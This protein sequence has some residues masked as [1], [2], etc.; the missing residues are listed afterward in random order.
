MTN[1]LALNGMKKVKDETTVQLTD[2]HILCLTIILISLVA[3]LSGME[4][5]KLA[6]LISRKQ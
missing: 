1:G 4:R 5:Y 3:L 6:V 2:T